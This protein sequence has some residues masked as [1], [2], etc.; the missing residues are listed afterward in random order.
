MVNIIDSVLSFPPLL[1]LLAIG[2]LVS[3]FVTL[4]SKFFTNQK[5]LKKLK[6]EVNEI[7]DSLK[8]FKHDVAKM[9]ELNRRMLHKSTEQ[10]RHSLRSLFFTMIPL[11]LLIAWMHSN[12]AA[13]NIMPGDTFSVIVEKD[14]RVAEQVAVSV[15]AIGATLADESS[16]DKTLNEGLLST[17]QQ[18]DF[19]AGE[20]GIARISYLINNEENYTQDVFV[21]SA[22]D[23]NDPVIE[24]D[25]KFLGVRYASGEIL[26]SSP[27][28]RIVVQLEPVRPFGNLSIFGWNPGWLFTYVLFTL[29]FSLLLRKALKVY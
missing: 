12:V 7:R 18:W 2:F 19:I 27:I 5:V 29:I 3:L 15:T 26:P 14:A 24:K 23:Y 28:S 6:E 25:K 16:A 11:L 17:T 21:T 1:V 13:E 9:A 20:E 4:V 8:E 22:W 10:M